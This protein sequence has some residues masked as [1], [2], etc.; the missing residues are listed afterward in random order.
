MPVVWWLT[1][2]SIF[3]DLFIGSSLALDAMKQEG[4]YD[5]NVLLAPVSLGL[6][7]PAWY[8]SL[9]DPYTAHKVLVSAAAHVAMEAAAPGAVAAA[10]T[11]AAGCGNGLCMPPQF[12]TENT[13]LLPVAQHAWHTMLWSAPALQV[14]SLAELS[15]R[16]HIHDGQPRCFERAMVCNMVGMYTTAPK[17]Q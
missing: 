10:T 4:A 2:F 3:G 15:S 9:L 17:H 6:R 14:V 7:L 1:Y 16:E 12:V 5:R 8:Q 13:R 11:V